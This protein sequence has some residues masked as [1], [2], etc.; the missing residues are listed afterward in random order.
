M[1]SINNV[2]GFNIVI[3]DAAPSRSSFGTI[4]VIA[5]HTVSPSRLV[6]DTTPDGRAGMLLDGFAATHDAYRK[7]LA[8]G[9]QN[10][11][12]PSFKLY[13]RAAPNAQALTLTPTNTTPGRKYE[14]ELNGVAV[15][16]TNGPAE[17]ATT[18][19]TALRTQLTAIPNVTA[20]GTTTVTLSLTSAAGARMY[21][22][23]APAYLTVKD[24]SPDAGIATDLDAA[25]LEDP[26]F[27]GVLIDSTSEAE[28]NAAAAWCQS[29]GKLLHA[30][31]VDS[32][33]L[34]SNATDV[35][36][37]L[38]AAAYSYAKLWYS[39]DMPAQLAASIMGRQFSRNPGSTTWENQ[40]LN[41]I[42]AD[43]LTPTELANAEGK[44]CGLYL[45]YGDTVA[46]TF[47]TAAASGRF[48]DITRDSDWLKA[49]AQADV[50][51]YLLNQE[52]VPFTQAGIDGVEGVL[53]AR[54][55]LAEN[56]GVLDEGW[57]I[58]LP[59]VDEID[60]ADKAARQLAAADTFAGIFQGAIHGV[61]LSGILA[62]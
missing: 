9:A 7:N 53:R 17:T 49:N 22:K 16:H 32:D 41:G 47:N 6:Y 29:N 19:C 50:L 42:V 59:T 40:R 13:N 55:Q 27:Y 5:H 60:P 52:K 30:Q 51:A 37:D 21:L 38:R 48:L 35:A 23:G 20:A 43:P 62:V 8:I 25:L 12:V 58:T 11:K 15:S 3:Q 33:V 28:I 34:T 61:Q 14:F 10:P 24:T 57:T 56:A 36:S 31:T 45:P 18:I 4:A 44:G 46:A 1:A 2:V 39:R 26:D 54:F